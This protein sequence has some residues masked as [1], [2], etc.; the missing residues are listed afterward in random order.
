MLYQYNLKKIQLEVFLCLH[1][2]YCHLLSLE[3]FQNRF[4]F[5]FGTLFSKLESSEICQNGADFI[6]SGNLML[7]IEM[8]YK[9]MI[10]KVCPKRNQILSKRFIALPTI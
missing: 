6:D 10:Y 8:T 5:K 7:F 1:H 9:E 4:L 2:L 3:T